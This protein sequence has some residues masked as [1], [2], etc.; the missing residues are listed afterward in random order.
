MIVNFK[1]QIPICLCIKNSAYK[2]TV[3][4]QLILIIATIFFLLFLRVKKCTQNHFWG[5]FWRVLRCFSRS[6]LELN[7]SLIFFAGTPP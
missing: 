6:A 1:N 2:L 7:L 4:F 5:N 3:F